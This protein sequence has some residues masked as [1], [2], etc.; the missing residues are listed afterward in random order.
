[1]CGACIEYLGWYIKHRSMFS[2]TVVHVNTHIHMHAHRR[3]HCACRLPNSWSNEGRHH[4]QRAGRSSPGRY[5]CM[6]NV[7]I[8]VCMLRAGQMRNDVFVKEMVAVP[9]ATWEGASQYLCAYYDMCGIHVIYMC[10]I[11]VFI[12]V[13]YT[14]YICVVYMCLYVWYT[15][16]IYVWYTYAYMCGIH[17]CLYTCVCVCVCV[18]CVCVCMIVY[19][20]QYVCV[21]ACVYVYIH[22]YKHTKTHVYTYIYT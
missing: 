7:C 15:R 16:H 1:M 22:A 10:G 19:T 8:V 3:D 18:Y 12:Y 17:L 20:C 21:Y 13:V 11:H 5:V 14:S 4:F 6:H 2:Y 9:K